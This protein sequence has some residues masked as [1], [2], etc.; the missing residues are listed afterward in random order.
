MNLKKRLIIA[1]SLILLI[2]WGI[3]TIWVWHETN[4]QMEIITDPN[5]TDTEKLSQIQVEVNEIFAAITFPILGVL[6]SAGLM[7]IAISN[8]FLKPFVELA[9]QLEHRN[10]LNLSVMDVSSSSKEASIIVDR[11]NY[12][13]LRIAQRIEYEKQFTADVAHELRTPLAGMR[14]TIELMD[15][16]PE[17]PLL[18]TRIDD[19]LVT[20][21]RLL[22]FA[23][24]SYEV[25]SENAYTFNVQDEVI[26]PLKNEYVDNYPHE[27]FW[28]V[29]SQ[30]MLRGDPSLIYL[31]MKNLLDNVKFYAPEGKWTTVSFASDHQKIVLKIIDNGQG[32]SDEHLAIMTQPYK[33]FD[34]TRSGSGLGLNIVERIVRAHNATLEINN[35]EDGETGLV[36]LIKFSQ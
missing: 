14:L 35:R 15:D 3:I 6:I 29:P 4:E 33:R 22:Q 32:M 2:S 17:K 23:R 24:A 30:L 1:L 19:L 13:L 16:I 28:D 21:E 7:I 25:H 20:I 36:I 11:L 8:R 26:E 5:L 31:L 27:I 34:Q 12:L 18:L 9:E 10:E